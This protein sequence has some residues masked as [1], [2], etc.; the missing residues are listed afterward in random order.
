MPTSAHS[1]HSDVVPTSTASLAAITKRAQ[2]AARSPARTS[3]T[4]S[5][6]PGVS[7]KLILVA[8]WTTGAIA[9]EIERACD[10][11]DSSKSQTVEPSWMVPARGMA[12]AVASSVSTR[13]VLPDPPGPTSTTFRIR[14][15]LLAPRSWPAGLR[16]PALSAISA[17]PVTAAVR[18]ASDRRAETMGSNQL[19]SG[20]EIKGYAGPDGRR[21]P[22]AVDEGWLTECADPPGSGVTWVLPF[23]SERGEPL[24]AWGQR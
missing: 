16:P 11:S 1:R 17:L 18:R 19:R 22:D 10:F 3:P 13:V 12:P 23:R 24:A 9:K 15:G 6:Y 14:P 7:M 5:A 21:P 2:S 4:K 8:R 20:L